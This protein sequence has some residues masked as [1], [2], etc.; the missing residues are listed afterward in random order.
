MTKILFL[1]IDGVLNSRR[2]SFALGGV[3]RAGLPLNEDNMKLFDWIA[4]G[5]IRRLCEEEGVSIVLSSSW[6]ICQKC[7]PLGWALELPIVDEIDRNLGSRGEQIQRWLNLHP[8]VEYY[9]IVDDS[10][11]ML[12][13]QGPHFVQTTY[14]DGL[15]YVHFRK[16]RDI[17]TGRL[18]GL[19]R[20]ALF[21]EQQGEEDD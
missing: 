11:D 20:N 18:G 17:L 1:D 3:P 5:M 19:Y 2:S 6:R 14:D 13:S 15:L 12:E 4:V 7:V 21:W 16:L 8:E 10:S 9:A